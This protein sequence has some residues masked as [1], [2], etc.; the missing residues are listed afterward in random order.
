MNSSQKWILPEPLVEHLA[1]HLRPPEVEAGEHREHDRA[2][3]HVVEVRDHE[4]AVGDVEVQRR[5]AEDD[6]GQPAEQERDQEADGPQHRRLEG[7]RAAPHRADPVEE[8]HPGRHRDQERHERRRTAAA[9]P[10]WRTCGAPTPRRTGRRSRAWRRPG[11]CSRRSACGEKT[12]MISVTMP[13][14][15]SAMMYTSGWPKNQNRCC[16]RIGPPLLG[17]EDV[18]PEPPVGLQR[19]QRGGQDGEGEQHQHRLVSRMFQVKIGIRN[20]VMPGRAHAEDRGDEVDRA[21]DRAE[22]GQR[23]AHDPQV[24]AEPG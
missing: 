16:H 11:P 8:L 24:G 7:E 19:E 15:G 4:V 5:R 2:E 18:R 10:R 21:Q 13:K 22:A 3:D 14:N 6:A 17:V 9:P 1:G 20:I 23:K 12:G